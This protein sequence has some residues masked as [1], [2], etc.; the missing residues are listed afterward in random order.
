MVCRAAS[1][2]SEKDGS[3]KINCLSSLW[4][5]SMET[6]G[7]VEQKAKSRRNHARYL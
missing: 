4:K 6:E 2:L 5:Q 3:R 7:V 1:M